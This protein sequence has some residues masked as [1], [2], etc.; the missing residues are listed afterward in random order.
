MSATTTPRMKLLN[1]L[2]AIIVSFVL[3]FSANLPSSITVALI[4]QRIFL[5][6]ERVH[7]GVL[8]LVHGVYGNAAEAASSSKLPFAQGERQNVL[9]VIDQQASFTTRQ[10]F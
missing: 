5:C 3:L 1:G 6:S 8:A 9:A 4:Q 7:K 2:L 10:M